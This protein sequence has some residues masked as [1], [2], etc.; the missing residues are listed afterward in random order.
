MAV[1]KRQRDKRR[2]RKNGP[3][4]GTDAGRSNDPWLDIFINHEVHFSNFSPIAGMHHV[5]AHSIHIFI[6]K[7][8]QHAQIRHLIHN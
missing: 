1:R 6:K 5:L 7:F 2:Q 3:S 4:Q 8:Y